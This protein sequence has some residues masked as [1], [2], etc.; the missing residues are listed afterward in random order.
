[1]TELERDNKDLESE[2]GMYRGS[3]NY[4]LNNMMMLQLVRPYTV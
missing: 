1:M 2:L 3:Q 4:G